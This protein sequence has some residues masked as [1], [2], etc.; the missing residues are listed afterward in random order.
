MSELWETLTTGL[1]LS[2]LFIGVSYFFWKR[3]DKPTPLMIERQEEK[4][5]LKEERKTWRQVEARLRAEQEEAELKAA[6]ERR[7]AEERAR[8]VVP[9]STEVK[10]AWK[11]LG[12][13][14]PEAA[15]FE[16]K[17][18]DANA[19][20]RPLDQTDLGEVAASDDDVLNA[21]EL[22]QVRQDKGVQPGAQEPDWELIEKLE[23]IAEKDDVELPDVPEA[24]DLDAVAAQSS[25][26]VPAAE[27]PPSSGNSSEWSLEED[28]DV[29]PASSE[30]E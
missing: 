3:Y 27:T 5:R 7:K 22:V 1:I 24:P 13:A 9:A 11:S 2:L 23:E 14:A 10:D 15:T 4:E 25:A 6:Y 12:V 19:D 8:S 30:E 16:A 26:Y 20:L 21:A 28:E 29:W 18:D 17:G